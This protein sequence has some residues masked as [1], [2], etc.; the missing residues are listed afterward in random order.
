MLT[1]ATHFSITSKISKT[2]KIVALFYIF[3]NLFY[4]CLKSRPIDS[5]C[6]IIKQLK[7]TEKFHCTLLRI[8]V[9]EKPIISWYY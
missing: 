3:S 4:M 5:F 7:T 9:G 8:K 2:N 6:C 1:S